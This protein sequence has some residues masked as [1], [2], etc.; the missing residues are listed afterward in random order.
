MEN[1]TRTSKVSVCEVVT[2][3]YEFFPEHNPLKEMGISDEELKNQFENIIGPFSEMYNLVLTLDGKNYASNGCCFTHISNLIKESRESFCFRLEG[4]SNREKTAF[5]HMLYV[6]IWN[7]EDEIESYYISMKDLENFD[8][9]SYASNLTRK[10]NE[11]VDSIYEYY[12]GKNSEAEVVIILDG[13]RRYATLSPNPEDVVVKAC[14]SKFKNCKF[15]MS[16][17]GDALDKVSKYRIKNDGKIGVH[18]HTLSFKTICSGKHN[19]DLF[20]KHLKNIC[21]AYRKENAIN[22][23]RAIVE[24]LSSHEQDYEVDTAF[25]LKLMEPMEGVTVRSLYDATLLYYNTIVKEEHREKMAEFA[26]T[27]Y[28]KKGALE[29]NNEISKRFVEVLREHWDLLDFMVAYH[30][31]N[32]IEND[33]RDASFLDIVVPVQVAKYLAAHLNSDRNFAATA[34]Q[35]F[36]DACTAKRMGTAESKKVTDVG[37]NTCLFLLGRIHEDSWEAAYKFLDIESERIRE[38][39]KKIRKEKNM[40]QYRVNI[41][42]ERTAEISKM[43]VS[44]DREGRLK[45]LSKVSQSDV[46]NEVNRVFNLRYYG[47]IPYDPSESDMEYS[48]TE[49]HMELFGRITIAHLRDA[50]EIYL[51]DLERRETAL[52]D[53]DIFSICAMLESKIDRGIDDPQKKKFVEDAQKLLKKYLLACRREN[54]IIPKDLEQYYSKIDEGFSAYLKE[55][56]S[57][58]RARFRKMLYEL[59][60]SEENIT[61]KVWF[62][63]LSVLPEMIEEKKMAKDYDKQKVLDTILLMNMKPM[64]GD[65][66]IGQHLSSGS[67]AIIPSMNRHHRIWNDIE[68]DGFNYRVALDLYNLYDMI[69]EGPEV[70]LETQVIRNVFKEIEKYKNV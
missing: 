33:V 42:M 28:L 21:K 9:G 32:M 8:W 2:R 53:L 13:V 67:S 52:L 56:I 63:G 15:V 70:K 35:F 23:V 61:L 1:E 44:N 20:E 66:D 38:S 69:C 37:Y 60:K 68:V 47:D 16:I 27:F 14:Q 30:I 5:L 50:L 57:L 34:T 59:K 22:K 55:G 49:E 17:D 7:K 62:F 18:H 39:Q 65:L 58:N 43:F 4:K 40:A 45:Y 51:S 46:H 12:K 3:T 64:L 29:W 48:E 10:A 41:F 54:V 19:E 31:V 24:K 6:H 26:F 11:I 36:I 25:I